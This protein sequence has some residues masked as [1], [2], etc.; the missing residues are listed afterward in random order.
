MVKWP[1]QFG[2]IVFGGWRPSHTF[3]LLIIQD[4]EM[5]SNAQILQVC[6][7]LFFEHSRIY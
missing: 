1:H 5:P 6:L 4:S 7:F 3:L 2:M